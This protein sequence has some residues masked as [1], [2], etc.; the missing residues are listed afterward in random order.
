MIDVKFLQ[1]EN[2]NFPINVIFIGITIDVKLLQSENA[3]FPIDVTLVGIVIDFNLIHLK[4][5]GISIFQSSRTKHLLY[6]TQRKGH[7]Y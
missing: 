7:R 3:E 2:V 1:L 6:I 5:I 4:N